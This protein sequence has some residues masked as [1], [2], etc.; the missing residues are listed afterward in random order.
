[1]SDAFSSS[2]QQSHI[3]ESIE[4]QVTLGTLNQKTQENLD[5]LTSQLPGALY[6]LKLF[7]DGR[8]CF[9]YISNGMNDV[10]E[11]MPHQV[12][13]DASAAFKLLHPD[14]Y[15]MVLK[16]IH[17]SA[18]T[19]EIWK[20]EY[21]VNLPKKGL[22]WHSGIANPER[23]DDGS[24]IWH[25]F[26]SDITELK[27]KDDEFRLISKR[28]KLATKAGGV[29]V[30]NWNIVDNIVDWDEQM[31]ALYGISKEQI[32]FTYDTWLNSLH[33]DDLHRCDS[34]IQM[35]LSGEKPFDTEFR[36]IWPDG[37]I[38][39]IRALAHIEL[40]ALG[41][42][43]NM[44]G[45][46]WDITEFKVNEQLLL[47]A[48]NIA[49]IAVKTKS[50]FIAN[51]SHEIRTPMNAILG[52]SE[53]LLGLVN[54]P[55]QHYYLDAI[56]RSGKTLLQLINDI[57]DLSKIEA[58]KVALQSKPI[59]LQVLIEDIKVIFSQQAIQ[60]SLNFSVSIDK[61][62]PC[63][64]LLDE[65]RLRQVLINLVGNALKFTHEGEVKITLSVLHMDVESNK[66]DLLI[67]IFDSGIGIPE[68]QQENIFS[69]FTQQ[70]NQGAEYGGTGLGLTISQRLLQLMNGSISVH[71][72]E[73][74]GSCFSVTLKD[75]LVC[76]DEIENQIEIKELKQPSTFQSAKILLVDDIVFNR[77][78]ILSYLA[79]FDSLIFVEASTGQE[80]LDSLQQQSFDLIFM[81]RRLPDMSGD[82]VC[83]KIKI[84]NP[85][86]PIIM[87]SASIVKGPEEDKSPIFYDIE[88]SKP[89]N[90]TALLKAM[91]VYLNSTQAE[92]V[93][94]ELLNSEDVMLSEKVSELLVLLTPYQ[95][96]FREMLN[97]GGL[98]I[99]L[100]IEMAE[101]LDEIAGRYH[102]S[103]L[104][105]WINTLKTQADLFDVTNLSKTLKGFD[106]LC[107]Q[108]VSLA[109][110][111]R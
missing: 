94:A 30:W 103:L 46:N 20:V 50:S 81:D 91:C 35:A 15:D 7:P 72:Q 18:E 47:N 80:A 105:E 76:N 17:K 16:S 1:V 8:L 33:P 110:I 40:D 39:N 31:C 95:N 101:Q 99:S 36:V 45:T 48:K 79:E 88:L 85:H 55:T 42:I 63:C 41:R 98:N 29:G 90:K 4:W 62:C 64:V 78:L 6:Q 60:K 58:D 12:L 100:L 34:E 11:I 74:E 109:D 96:T 21:R 51:M 89:V 24:T 22:R 56:N 75:V 28:L 104:N 83:Q 3:R 52:F 106:T 65:I 73:G 108:I 69:A 53:I 13:T 27:A 23:L 14:D 32:N 5:K 9:P 61:K 37:T 19:L 70:E 26:I 43:I 10:F 93:S 84:L 86:I 38:H 111:A 54:E 44:T 107:G 67:D 71:S 92:V 77:K 25:G 97:T 57:L 49:E 2:F 82:S 59:S 87:V 68:P 66:V 102:C